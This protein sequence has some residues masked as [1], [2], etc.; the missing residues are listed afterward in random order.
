MKIITSEVFIE[1]ER[2]GRYVVNTGNPQYGKQ[3]KRELLR[4]GWKPAGRKTKILN[5]HRT[6]VA[7]YKRED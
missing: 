4:L 2:K 1:F 3:I 6:T 7:K 5:G